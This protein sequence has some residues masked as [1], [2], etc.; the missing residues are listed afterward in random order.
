[1]TRW[2][3]LSL[4]A[5]GCGGGTIGAGT[6]A[7]DA[8]PETLASGDAAPSDVAVDP[9]PGDGAA[10]V[11]TSPPP[12]PPEG[13]IPIFVAQGNVGRTTISCDDGQSWVANRSDD[14]TI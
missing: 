2:I 7:E 4:F 6:V 9:P 12:P 13:T 1:M 8:A 10:A 14:D 5:V 3:A 11:D